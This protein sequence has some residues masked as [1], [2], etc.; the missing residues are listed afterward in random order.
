MVAH[1]FLDRFARENGKSGLSF[2][3]DAQRAMQRHP[4]PG[5][6]RELQNRIQRGV[7]MTDGK[8]ITAADLDLADAS[9]ASAASTLKEARDSLDREMVQRALKR[10]GGKIAPAASELR[11]QPPHFLRAHGKARH[12]EGVIA[13][14]IQPQSSK[15]P[16]VH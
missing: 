14:R 5:N 1:A 7:I 4:W 8:R 6:V 11:N 12:R 2:A 15:N 9:E 3:P 13:P 10:H 16:H